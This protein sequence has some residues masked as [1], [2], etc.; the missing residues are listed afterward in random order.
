MQHF[1]PDVSK[2]QMR[3]E[4]TIC[5]RIYAV[6]VFCL[7]LVSSHGFAA[8]YIDLDEEAQRFRDADLVIVGN[9]LSRATNILSDEMSPPGLDGWMYRHRTVVDI[10]RI[11][12][13]AMLKGHLSDPVIVVQSEPYSPETERHRFDRI[14]GK[15]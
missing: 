1:R 10:Y 3:Y 4:A 9:V 12:I 8:E 15:R 11:E 5:S 13:D 2:N 6:A 7:M 14:E